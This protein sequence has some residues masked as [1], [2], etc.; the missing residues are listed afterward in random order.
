[1]SIFN[2][3]QKF[4]IKPQGQSEYNR[5][6]NGV[7]LTSSI[8]NHKDVNRIGEIVEVPLAYEGD[9]SP[10]DLVVVHH[11]VFRSYYDMKGYERKSREYFKDN[12]YLVDITQ[13]YLVKKDS[14][15]SSFDDFCF[16]TPKEEEQESVSL[17]KYEKNIGVMAY[18]SKS[19][20]HSGVNNGDQV[21]YTDDSEYQ[22]TI[23]DQ[24]MYRMR[25]KDI[26]I[27]FN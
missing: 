8:E 27:K 10:G 25:T 4:L 1:M 21:A 20:M 15:W 7:V 3:L 14:S 23:D 24:L 9:I 18:S 19:L 16:V 11:N 6:K 22:F 2:P 12:L 13:I 5:E 26:C 17:D